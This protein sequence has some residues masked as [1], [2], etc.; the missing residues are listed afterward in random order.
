MKNTPATLA[1][2]KLLPGWLLLLAALT[3]IG[4]LSIDMYLPSFPTIAQQLGVGS[5]LVQLTLAS[6]LV[7]LAVG[8]MFYG[9]LSGR[10]GRKPPLY[11]GMTL[12][13]LGSLACMLAQDVTA[14]IVFRFLQGLGGCAGMVIGRAVIRDRLGTTGAAR[15]FSLMMLVM[16]LAP[17]IGGAVLK[18]WGWRVIFG[19]LTGFGLFCLI[20][21][22]YAMQ[23]TLDRHQAEPLHLGR[24]IK[25]Y[26]RLL[27]DRQ[28]VAY[29]LVGGLIQGGVFAYITGSSFVLIELH[30]IKPENF[31]FVFGTNAFGLIAASQ[32]NARLVG[33]YTLDTILG[34]ALWMPA[35]LSVL[36]ALLVACGVNSLPVLLTGFFG[37]LASYGFISPNASA[38]ALSQ[39]GKQAGTASALMGTLQFAIGITS[40]VAM[41]LWHDGT[42]LPLMVVMAACGMGG[43]LLHRCIARPEHQR[44]LQVAAPA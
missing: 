4:S 25:Q 19:G 37:Y 1:P 10:F 42:A 8:Q 23:E 40:G 27:L 13:V 36:V 15:A 29:G 21:I 6:F 14:L 16:G 17:L 20:A 28:F 2:E 44:L 30:G 18:L 43:L 24:T 5:N 39:Q 35:V 12:Y 41:S 26:G 34:R 31:G 32:V 3:A 9:P 22:H 38:I 33:K 7:G 11:V